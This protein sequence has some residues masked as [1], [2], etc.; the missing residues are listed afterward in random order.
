MAS[1]AWRRDGFAWRVAE[2]FEGGEEL[3]RRA[4]TSPLVA[5]ILHN[6]GVDDP[7]DARAFLDPQL[8]QL[9]DPALLSGAEAAA[10][11]IARAVE[12]QERIVIYGDYDV[13]GITAVAI[14]YACLRLVGVEPRYYVPHRLD[15]G[16]GVNTEAIDKLIAEGTDLLI[17]VDCGVSATEPLARARAAG[18]DVIVTDHHTPPD[19]LPEATAIVHPRIG[20]TYPNGDLCGAGVAFKVAWQVARA[21]CGEQRVDEKMRNFLLEA[22]CLAALGTIAD[23]VPL[24]GENRAIAV[25]GL[26]GLPQTPRPGLAALL[27]SARLTGTKLD[28]FDVGFRLAPRLNA[29]GRMG[30]A[31][32]AIEMLTRAD[33]KRAREIAEYLDKQNTQRQKV[34]REISRQAIEM[35]EAAGMDAPDRRT[36]VLG[37]DDWHGGVIG[38]VASR[39]VDRFSKP[40]MLIAH[41]GGVSQGSGRS[42]AGFHL[43][44]ALSACAEHLE[45]FGGHAMAAG[46]RIRPEKVADLAAAMEHFA[47]SHGL[48]P[49]PL[50][51]LEI[52]AEAT[53]ASLSY[54]TV[55]HVTRLAPF[56]QGNP[57]PLVAIRGLKVLMPPQRMGRTGQTVGMTL[58]QGESNVRAVGFSMGDLADLLVGVNEVDVA[59][60]PVFNTYR[61]RTSVELH[62]RDVVWR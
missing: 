21:I 19:D 58:N 38:I 45:S 42:V 60:Q 9:H 24:V 8:N 31:R 18:I 34:E 17:T 5:Q 36:I 46:V 29:A 15:E 56:G 35:V 16:Y 44:E 43:Y 54:R 7:D 32:L 11:R 40:T 1:R 13:D 47:Q 28:A 39:L 48:E 51:P 23:V 62:L 53:L 57:P 49:S 20:G 30:H 4:Q 25:Y 3:A 33:E 59:A 10:N 6:R 41:N 50:P 55:E 27:E 37:C 12:K 22:T 26:R 61:G 14:L 52:D 2:A